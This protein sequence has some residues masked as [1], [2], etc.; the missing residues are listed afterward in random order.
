M[1]KCRVS[2]VLDLCS[3]ACGPL[4]LLQ[5][6]LSS[7][8]ER[9]VK[10]VLSDKFPNIGAFQEAVRETHGALNFIGTPVD[11]TATPAEL[12][13]FRTLFNAFHHFDPPAA[14]SILQDAA[15]NRAGIGVFEYTERSLVWTISAILSPLFFWVTGPIAVRPFT[16]AAFF[17]IYL[18]P[19]PVIFGTWDALIS[20]LRTYSTGALN[21]LAKSVNAPDYVWEVGRV[22]SFGACHVTYLIGYPCAEGSLAPGLGKE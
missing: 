4:A 22:R 1:R 6:Q 18:F 12:G 8:L 13:G 7:E 15:N 9:E 21:E 3:G 11:A 10:V 2:S 16:P 14:R 19:L 20:C 17:W 5:R